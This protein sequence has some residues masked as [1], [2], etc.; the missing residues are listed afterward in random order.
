MRKIRALDA[1]LPATRRG[2]L[3]ATFGRPDKAWYVSELAR[4]MRVPASSLQRELRDLTI[5]EILKS[6][7]QGR[8]VYYQANADSPIFPDLYGLLL[9]TAG[10]VD[11]LS[12]ALRPLAAKIRVAFVFGSIA[13][14]GEQ[15]KSDVDL[16][17]VGTV[18][19]IELAR[20]LLR[21]RELIG[22]EINPIVYSPAE[23]AQKRAEN[24]HFLKRVFESP[25]LIVLGDEDELGPAGKTRLR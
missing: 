3:A 8:M 13:S 17:V 4:R 1:L 19:S 5:A 11:V 21:A 25:R 12:D 6:H 23:F 24:N 18:P 7:R 22:R 9:K 14:G 15:S 2:I 20:P 16:M 10:L